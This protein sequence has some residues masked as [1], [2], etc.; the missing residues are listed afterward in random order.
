MDPLEVMQTGYLVFQMGL[1]VSKHL[2][3]GVM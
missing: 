2:T 1:L 3:A